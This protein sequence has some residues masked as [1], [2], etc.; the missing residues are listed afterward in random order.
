MT[1]AALANLDIFE[2]DFAF[3]PACT[4]AGADRN[5]TDE[6]IHLAAAFRGLGIRHGIATLWPIGDE[7][8]A[9]ATRIVYRHLA[10]DDDLPD[11]SASD[12]AAALH[13]ATADLRSATP[14]RPSNWAAYAHYGP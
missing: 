7:S 12:S 8:A 2:A 3:L 10:P 9:R 1:I 11:W 13:A 6:P 5:L 4:T 14:G